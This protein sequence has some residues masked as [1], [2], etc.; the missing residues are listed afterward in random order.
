MLEN[1]SWKMKRTVVVKL[2][3]L[4]TGWYVQHFKWLFICKTAFRVTY[5]L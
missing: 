2:E 5:F 3:D 4:S 1:I